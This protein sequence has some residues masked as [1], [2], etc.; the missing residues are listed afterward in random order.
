MGGIKVIRYNAIRV[1]TS[2]ANVVLTFPHP[3]ETKG[4]PTIEVQ[5]MLPVDKTVEY[6]LDG[7][8]VA[9]TK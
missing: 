5:A 2:Y 8:I 9:R 1:L 4:V 3:I 7:Q 6:M